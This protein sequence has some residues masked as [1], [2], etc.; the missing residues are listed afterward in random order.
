MAGALD[1]WVNQH[2]QLSVEYV[3]PA[4]SG[5]GVTNAYSEPQDLGVDRWL[6]IIAAYQRAKGAVCVI[7]CGTA[8]TVDVV[9]GKGQH[10]GGLILPGLGM[11]RDSL[12]QRAEGIDYEP[13]NEPFSDDAVP[14]LLAND[15]QGAVE[16]GSLYA[17]IAFIERVVADLER[18]VGQAMQ[19]LLTG[20]DAPDIE[21]LLA[22]ELDYSPRLVLEGLA[23]MAGESCAGLSRA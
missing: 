9:D 4:A 7:D 5:F 12:L 22:R 16:A 3:H 18:E 20:G 10:L 1:G 11:M 2:W 14:T 8:L 15:T 13:E 23:L 17:S 21:P 19:V 6:A